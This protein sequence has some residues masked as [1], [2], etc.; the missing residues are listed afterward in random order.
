MPKGEGQEAQNKVM[1]KAGKLLFGLLPFSHV[2][3]GVY[4]GSKS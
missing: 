1:N 4:L 2:W 3:A